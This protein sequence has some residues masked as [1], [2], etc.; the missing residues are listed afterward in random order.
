LRRLHTALT[1]GAFGGELAEQ[2]RK[3]T[4]VRIKLLHGSTLDCLDALIEAS[5]IQRARVLRLSEKERHSDRPLGALNV[6]TR[7]YRDL[8]LAIQNIKFDLGLDAYRRGSPTVSE[9]GGSM[10]FPDGTT[11]EQRLREA[12]STMEEIFDRRGIPR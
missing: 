12:I 6:A 11:R 5:L 7:E 3:S 1:N 2:A 10:T 4:S 9:F 8:L